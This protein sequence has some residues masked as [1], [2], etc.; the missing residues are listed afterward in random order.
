MARHGSARLGTAARRTCGR[1]VR[2]G[3]LL[4]AVGT[5]HRMPSLPPVTL[6]FTS[7]PDGL[8]WMVWA[9]E[10]RLVSP[11]EGATLLCFSGAMVFTGDAL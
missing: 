11:L 4:I 2:A 5:G 9:H 6:L 10:R 8:T 1:V 3:V 7:I